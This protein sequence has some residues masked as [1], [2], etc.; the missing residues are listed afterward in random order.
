MRSQELW[1]LADAGYSRD[2]RER[3]WRGDTIDKSEAAFA[4]LGLTGL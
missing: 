3:E 1:R 2:E 4:E